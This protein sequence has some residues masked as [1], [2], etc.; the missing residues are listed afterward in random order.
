MRGGA[1][2]AREEQC[3]GQ[4]FYR[5]NLLVAEPHTFY[6]QSKQVRQKINL[7]DGK[8]AFEREKREREDLNS[9]SGAA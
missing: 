4:L 7:Y 5:D 3:D 2:E 1:K 8:Y 9:P 6:L